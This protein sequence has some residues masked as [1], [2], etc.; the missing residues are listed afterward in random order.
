MDG[1]GNS[2]P[3]LTGGKR[4]HAAQGACGVGVHQFLETLTWNYLDRRH[5]STPRLMDSDPID[6]NAPFQ[7]SSSVFAQN[8]SLNSTISIWYINRVSKKMSFTE[9]SIFRFAKNI[10]SISSQLAALYPNAQFGKTQFFWTPCIG[11]C[12]CFCLCLSCHAYPA[13]NVMWE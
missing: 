1:N 2:R 4:A 13:L 7:I 9:L 6:K 3:P 12:L 11:L 10:I 5:I 8:A